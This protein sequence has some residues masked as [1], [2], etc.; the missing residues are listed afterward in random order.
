[1]RIRQLY[2]TFGT[3]PTLCLAKR[4]PLQG[5]SASEVALTCAHLPSPTEPLEQPGIADVQQYIRQGHIP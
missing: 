2:A 3:S 1:M 4:F 5:R